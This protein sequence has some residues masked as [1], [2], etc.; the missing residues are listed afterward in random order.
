MKTWIKVLLVVLCVGGAVASYGDTFLNTLAWTRYV[1]CDNGRM[2]TDDAGNT[3]FV[4]ISPVNDARKGLLTFLRY[5][6][7]GNATLVHT[8]FSTGG[9]ATIASVQTYTTPT[10]HHNFFVLF[11][12]Y[13]T[14]HNIDFGEFDDT[15]STLLD[16]NLTGTSTTDLYALNAAIDPS[17]AF[18]IAANQVFRGPLYTTSEFMSR[19]FKPLGGETIQYDSSEAPLSAEFTKQGKWSVSGTD[20]STSSVTPRWALV[21][22]STGIESGSASFPI[23]DNGTY[24]YEYEMQ[25]CADSAGLFY[26][27]VTVL[28]YKDTNLHLPLATNHFLRKYGSGGSIVWTSKSYTGK[29]EGV[30]CAS[31]SG[32]VWAMI[33][34][35]KD[36]RTVEQ[37]DA[38]GFLVTHTQDLVVFPGYLQ[39]PDLTGDY[40]LYT[41]Y[42]TRKQIVADRLGNAGDLLWTLSTNTYSG[43]PADNSSYINAVETNGNL[44][45]C[46]LLPANTQVALQRYVK[47]TTLSTLTGGTVKGG[48]TYSLKV[49]LNAPAPTGGT[50]L[51]LTS[52]NAKL[53]FPN[54][55]TSYSTGVP[56][57]SIYILVTMHSSVVSANT[58]VTVT[59]NQN[60][61]VRAAAVTVTP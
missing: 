57:G 34:L 5:D 56:A 47:G 35:G 36:S 40:F 27:M 9:P 33:L 37:F 38:N 30:V 61:V 4:Y 49:S 17:G 22:P 48:S 12:A 24:R 2:A 1:A 15:G 52:N 23:V 19:T 25:N 53:L 55:Q 45:T 58:P 42:N 28:E 6:I 54:G 20:N 16:G 59:G 60:G 14:T 7:S 13:T 50:G 11:S 39:V 46:A 8:S 10:G 51:I 26:S 21:D 18:Y 32:S 3:Y 31:P 41:N 29:P 43:A 44:Y